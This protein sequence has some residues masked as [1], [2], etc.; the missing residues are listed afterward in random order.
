MH[1]FYGFFKVTCSAASIGDFSRGF[2]Q[3]NWLWYSEFLGKVFNCE[4]FMPPFLWRTLWSWQHKK[5]K[6]INNTNCSLSYNV[7][8]ITY[9]SMH[10]FKPMVWAL[11]VWMKLMQSTFSHY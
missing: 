9:L 10:S 8:Q 5:K 6:N 7:L 11:V 2:F 3:M 1:L 4:I